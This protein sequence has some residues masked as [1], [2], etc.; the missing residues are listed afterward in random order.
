[1]MK[2]KY[3]K[4]VGKGAG[5]TLFYEVSFEPQGEYKKLS[6]RMVYRDGSLGQPNTF[7]SKG[8]FKTYNSELYEITKEQ[9]KRVC[10]TRRLSWKS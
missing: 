5:K 2:T 4:S 3:Y 9:F 6:S 1:M 7:H 10:I 8:G